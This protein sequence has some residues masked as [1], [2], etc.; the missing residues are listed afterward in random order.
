M[1]SNNVRHLIYKTITTLQHFLH[2]TQLHFTALHPTT[3]HRTSPNHTSPHFTQQH[4]TTDHQ[5]TN[6]L[7]SPNHTS[8]H[9]TQLHFTTLHSHIRNLT[10]MHVRYRQECCFL[11]VP[12][13]VHVTR[14]L[15]R[16][17]LEQIAKPGHTQP[18]HV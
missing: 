11:L 12:R 18:V 9:V 10:V 2:F 16:P 5:T 1:S 3:I 8:P 7:Q 4:F 6:H 14:T 13:T 17:V 15:R